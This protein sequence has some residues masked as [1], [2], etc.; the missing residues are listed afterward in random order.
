MVKRTFDI[1]FSFI[2]LVLLSPL[3]LV[4]MILI[5]IDSRGGI[6][7]AQTRVG[8]NGKNFRLWKF[9]TM[10]VNAESSG[11]LTVGSRDKRITRVGYYL[12][13]FKVDELPQLWNVL[14]GKMSV[15]GPRPEVPKYVAMYNENQRKVLSVR[16]GITD[17]ASILYFS[18]SELLAKSANPESTYIN[19]IMPAKLKLNLDYIGNMGIIT[20]IKIVF[21]T[22]RRI[23]R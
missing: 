20:D 9:R 1:L 2:M 12:R 18:E 13:K 8:L 10:H 6:F 15:V 23:F 21:A 22:A 11:Q 17:Y 7:F 16:P 4:L 3:L 19:E 14:E 5:S